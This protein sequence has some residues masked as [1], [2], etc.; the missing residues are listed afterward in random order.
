MHRDFWIDRWEENRLGWHQEDAH[1]LLVKFI[2]AHPLPKGSRI[3]VPLCGK[4][5]DIGWLLSQG[6]RVVA[7]ELSEIAI[8]Q[9]F[10]ELQT[11][12]A[13]QKQGALTHFSA[14]GLDVYVGDVFDLTKIQ[15]GPVDLIHDRAAMVALPD[16]MRARYVSHLAE[17]TDV[18]R[19]FVI[20]FNY[21]QELISGPPFSVPQP[22]IK[23]LYDAFYRSTLLFERDIAGGLKGVAPASEQAW[24]VESR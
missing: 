17:I 24:L 8:R 14:T 6:Y 13:V 20:S 16:D 10:D 21:D 15:I 11:E 22:Q 18:A 7:A 3:F 4:T 1:P 9:L 5:R 23:A 12:P 2:G 19:Q